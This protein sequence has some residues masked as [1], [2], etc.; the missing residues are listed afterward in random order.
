MRPLT[1]Q[2][3]DHALSL[4]NGSPLLDAGTFHKKVAKAL[5]DILDPPPP[6]I[7]IEGTYD[8]I[9]GALGDVMVDRG[10]ARTPMRQ[11][12]ITEVIRALEMMMTKKSKVL[13]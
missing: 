4:F 3:I 13:A 7:K 5:N 10:I 8:E 12:E 11:Y 2:D 9:E 6:T 1:A